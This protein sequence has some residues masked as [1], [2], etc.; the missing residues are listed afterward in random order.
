[1]LFGL[2][3]PTGIGLASEKGGLLPTTDWKKRVY[4]EPW[5]LGET[6]SV[7]IGQGFVLTTPLQLAAMINT[8]AADGVWRPPQLLKKAENRKTG[9]VEEVSRSEGRRLPISAET[10]RRIR[11]ALVAVVSDSHGTAAASRSEVVSIGGKT[12]TAQVVARPEDEEELPE[13]LNDHAW[14]AAYAP[15][16]N[17]EIAVVVLVE[18]GG[19]GGA[20]A[21]PLARDVI[22]AYLG[23]P[24]TPLTT[25]RDDLA[26]AQKERHREIINEQLVDGVQ[27]AE[28][29]NHDRS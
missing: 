28:E 29:L 11:D 25:A 10:F 14:F 2:G 5:Y 22:E 27:A 9:T 21:A 13:H 7:S 20:T 3:K 1:A 15:V 19:H 8:V 6:L 4:K 17:P 26:P 23:K 12:G 18:N 24:A 16:E